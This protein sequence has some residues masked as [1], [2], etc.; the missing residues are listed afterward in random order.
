MKK[1]NK[2]IVPGHFY[3]INTKEIRGHKG[4]VTKKFGDKRI[5][6]IITHS[7]YTRGRKNIK[8]NENPQ[9]D[10]LEFS[11]VVKKARFID[12]SKIGKHH[13]DIIVR[14]SVDKSILRNIKNKKKKGW[15]KL[16]S[17]LSLSLLLLYSKK[18][19]SQYLC[20]KI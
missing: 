8:L 5:A 12:D 7:Q 14:D 1:Q 6:V 17:F 18:L 15:P 10:D 9:K 19:K 20:K 13:E 4:Q 11:Y 2:K 3:S 16:N